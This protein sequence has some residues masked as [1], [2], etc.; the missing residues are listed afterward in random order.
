MSIVV[1]GV[2]IS[3]NCNACALCDSDGYCLPLFEH[4]EY[5]M[6]QSRYYDCPILCEL[7][8]KHGRLIDVDDFLKFLK[9]LTKH[10]APYQSVMELLDKS[11]KI[12]V[13]AEG[14]NENSI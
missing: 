5:G 13:E 7:P 12:I 14:E 2:K 1:K 8:E 4:I 6:A 3:K 10:G 9:A 11:Q